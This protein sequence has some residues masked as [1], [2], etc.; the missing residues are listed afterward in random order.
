MKVT[1]LFLALALAHSACGKGQNCVSG[2]CKTPDPLCAFGL[3]RCG[4]SCVSKLLDP[5]NCGA[6]GKAVCNG[7][8]TDITQDKNNCGSCGK[9]DQSLTEWHPVYV[10]PEVFIGVVPA[11]HTYLHGSSGALRLDMC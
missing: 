3:Y 8:C 11:E 9:V 2:S 4:T 10:R 1:S 5:N 6:C 7:Q